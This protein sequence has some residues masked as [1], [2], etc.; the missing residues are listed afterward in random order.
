MYNK[1][2]A[3]GTLGDP[4][5]SRRRQHVAVH[6]NLGQ[7]LP[8]HRQQSL[9]QMGHLTIRISYIQRRIRKASS[10]ETPRSNSHLLVVNLGRLSVTHRKKCQT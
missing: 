1:E 6:P 8:S 5:I 3:K 2:N 4:G 7:G 10:L 9:P